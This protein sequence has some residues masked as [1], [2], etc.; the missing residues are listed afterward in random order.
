MLV[1]VLVLVVV[2]A[3]AVVVVFVALNAYFNSRYLEA[4]CFLYGVCNRCS[5]ANYLSLIHI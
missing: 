2:F 3:V 5:K 1:V 4:I